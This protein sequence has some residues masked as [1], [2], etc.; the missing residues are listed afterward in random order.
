MADAKDPRRLHRVETV[1][2]AQAVDV[3]RFVRTQSINDPELRSD[4]LSDKA[5]GKAQRGRARLLPALWDGL[6]CFR[7]LDLARGRWKDIAELAAA[8]EET[9]RVGS[10]IARVALHGDASFAY[11]DLDHADGHLTVWGSPDELVA[12]TVAIVAAEQ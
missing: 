3:F 9:P 7:T 2:G 11:E 1:S 4:F 8:R 5:A 6:S 10:F 12:Y